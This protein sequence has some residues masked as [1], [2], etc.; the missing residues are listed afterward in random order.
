MKDNENKNK[1]ES[2]SEDLETAEVVNDLSEENAQILQQ[3]KQDKQR[4]YM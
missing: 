2:F 1:K 3:Y 4:T